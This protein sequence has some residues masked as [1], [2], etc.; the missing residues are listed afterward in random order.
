MD[1]ETKQRIT[2]HDALLAMVA[3]CADAEDGAPDAD[4][5]VEAAMAALG[6]KIDAYRAV[7]EALGSQTAM[8]RG[9]ADYYRDLA[10]RA[11]DRSAAMHAQI[12]RLEAR[13]VD[14][15]A[16]AGVDSLPGHAWIVSR[17]ELLPEVVADEGFVATVDLAKWVA[18]VPADKAVSI[19][20]KPEAR[21]L[22][23][24][25]EPVPWSLRDR[26]GVKWTMVGSRRKVAPKSQT[27]AKIAGEVQE[28]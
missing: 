3:A 20:G 7:V 2:L 11:S 6:D 14:E 26:V 24:L 13:M 25:G 15:M 17:R 10:R 4:K 12:E 16:T 5:A 19:L 18:R 28:L 21:E 1:N 9:E 23:R 27:P 8:M 22:A